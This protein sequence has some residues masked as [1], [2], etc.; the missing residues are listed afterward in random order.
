MR[1]G[2]SLVRR[3]DEQRTEH[4][5]RLICKNNSAAEAAWWRN[6]L[7]HRIPTERLESERV[8]REKGWERGRSE[9]V[10]SRLKSAPPAARPSSTSLHHQSIPLCI[11]HQPAIPSSIQPPI[12]PLSLRQSISSSSKDWL[13]RIK[14]N[15]LNLINK[16]TINPPSINPSLFPCYIIITIIL[17]TMPFLWNITLFFYDVFQIHSKLFSV[18]KTNKLVTSCRWRTCNYNVIELCILKIT[19]CEKCYGS[20]NPVIT[21]PAALPGD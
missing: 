1:R 12:P 10:F 11:I 15:K 14:K 2:G 4:R 18:K 3:E 17:N 20:R 16:E 6:K 13:I 19:V 21:K 8:G 9:G 7:G 5:L